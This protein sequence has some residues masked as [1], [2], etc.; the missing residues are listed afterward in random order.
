MKYAVKE[1][2][3]D[4]FE[5]FGFFKT[6]EEAQAHAEAFRKFDYADGADIFQK[7]GSGYEKIDFE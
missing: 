2:Y 7:T 3:F 1:I 6:K 5:W 4:G